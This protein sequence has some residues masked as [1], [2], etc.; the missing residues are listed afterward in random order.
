MDVSRTRRSK[1]RWRPERTGVAYRSSDAKENGAWTWI[2][3]YRILL[4]NCESIGRPSFSASRRNAQRIGSLSDETARDKLPGDRGKNDQTQ[5]KI[6]CESQA[7]KPTGA[8]PPTQKP[9]F[10]CA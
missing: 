10:F 6:L 5:R 1:K 9:A 7:A 2:P 8:R 4:H 3:V